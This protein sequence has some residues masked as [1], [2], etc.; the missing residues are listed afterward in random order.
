MRGAHL[1]L[2][3]LLAL[4]GTCAPASGGRGPLRHGYRR[5]ATV[6]R[7]IACDRLEIR[8]LQGGRT[9]ELQDFVELAVARPAGRGITLKRLASQRVLLVSSQ[10]QK[11]EWDVYAEGAQPSGTLRPVTFHPFLDGGVLAL[12]QN[13]YVVR[14][15]LTSSRLRPVQVFAEGQHTFLKPGEVLLVLD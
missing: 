4:T 10:Q 13:V 14:Q 1:F 15:V 11:G 8:V 6:V 9:V 3:L 7:R 12:P 2:G 5:M